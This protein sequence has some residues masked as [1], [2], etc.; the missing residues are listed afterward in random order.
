MQCSA[1]QTANTSLCPSLTRT[2]SSVPA[3]DTHLAS[4]CTR[5]IPTSVPC[6]L[7]CV[8]IP[9]KHKYPHTW[10]RGHGDY[11]SLQ[12]TRTHIAQQPHLINRPA[13]KQS[14]QLAGENNICLQ[15]HPGSHKIQPASAPC[16]T[17]PRPS[18]YKMLCCPVWVFSW[19]KKGYGVKS[20]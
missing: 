6:R 15:G 7:R 1:L 16:A 13:P 17:P 20:L 19:E 11:I 5:G 3:E 18:F 14:M 4:L 12:P 10:I 9:R 2:H 8:L